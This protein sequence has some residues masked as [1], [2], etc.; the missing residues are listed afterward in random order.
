MRT[1]HGG[2]AAR[3]ACGGTC[4]SAGVSAAVPK[5]FKK[6][7]D[8]DEIADVAS[9]GEDVSRYFTNKFEVV[10]P[11]RRVNVDPTQGRG[12]RITLVLSN[13]EDVQKIP[14]HHWGMVRGSGGTV[15]R[16]PGEV[17]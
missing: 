12:Y 16:G 17:S 7:P 1:E 2:P 9:R 4:W 10:R 3:R 15:F 11:V 5:T 6:I 8:A 13:A 14:T